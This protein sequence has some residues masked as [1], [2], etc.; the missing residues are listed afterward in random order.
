M[1]KNVLNMPYPESRYNH[2]RQVTGFHCF[3]RRQRITQFGS[4]E[5][6]GWVNLVK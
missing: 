4:P 3:S 2:P 1:Y 6:N 5:F